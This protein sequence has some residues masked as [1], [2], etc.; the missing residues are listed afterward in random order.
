MHDVIIIG[1]RCAGSA[2][3]LLL[4]RAG[5]KV[6]VVERKSF[7]SDTMS[8]HYI[9]PAGISFLRRHN[10][11]D[12]LIATRT[13]PQH[14]VRVD[15]GPIALSGTPAPA[16]DGTTDGYAPRRYIFDTMLAE[17]AGDAGAET[18]HETNFIAPIHENGRVVGIRGTTRDGREVEAR[19]TIVVGADG[20]RSKFAAAVKSKLYNANPSTGCTYYT[21]WSG[22]DAPHTHLFVREGQFYVIAPT[23]D[24]LTFM[25]IVWPI[26]EFDRVR[27]DLT[28]AY[29]SAA[30]K[31]DWI[32]DRLAT[33]RQAER[34]IGT[35]DLGGFFRQPHGPGW[36]LVGDAG[37]HKDPIT[38]QG[39]TDALLHSELLAGAILCGLETGRSLE[40]AL[41]S[42]HRLRDKAV[43][44]MYSITNE[45]ARLAAPPPEVAALVASI[46][47]NPA[48]TR[49]Y[50]GLISGTVDI[51]DYFQ[52]ENL[53]ELLGGKRAA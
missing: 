51:E 26:E 41:S 43:A 4:A 44:P 47:D 13:P 8:G 1:A 39:M 21:Y 30:A 18:W 32:A 27:S 38:A 34:F 31:V 50:L 2:L 23:N 52:P 45:M 6:L 17:A 11:L 20:K 48:E 7:P 15:F 29:R 37:Y 25:G 22:F 9:H 28:A 5:M 10:L 14:T 12:R 3:A 42:Y 40:G 35:S 16:A 33:A 49:R 36:A 53:N 24:G 46:R 19:A